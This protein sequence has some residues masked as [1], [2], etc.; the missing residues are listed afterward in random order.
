MWRSRARRI[1]MTMYRSLGIALAIAGIVFLVMGIN[2]T[3]S[4]VER[5]SET[6]TGKFTDQ[7]IW[8]IAGGLA[9]LIGGSVLAVSARAR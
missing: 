2:A 3:D 6:F 1:E 5:V 8:Y 7:T 9:A 4:A